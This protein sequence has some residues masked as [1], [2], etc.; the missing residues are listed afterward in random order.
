MANT[1]LLKQNQQL[2]RKVEQLADLCR[3]LTSENRRGSGKIEKLN[4]EKVKTDNQIFDIYLLLGNEIRENSVLRLQA[5]SE[6]I[7]GVLDNI[8]VLIKVLLH[9]NE[10]SERQNKSLRATIKALNDMD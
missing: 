6:D 3:D 9:N 8:R 7:S 10:S 4:L 1:Q 5:D 2:G